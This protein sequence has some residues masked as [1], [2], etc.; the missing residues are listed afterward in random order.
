MVHH[1]LG[2][3]RERRLP[4]PPWQGTTLDVQPL[5]QRLFTQSLKS[6][7]FQEQP[8]AAVTC[9]HRL[10]QGNQKVCREGCNSLSQVPE[11]LCLEEREP[12]PP[13]S[14]TP[15]IAGPSLSTATW[16]CSASILPGKGTV[17]WPR[18]VQAH[19]GAQPSPKVSACSG[20]TSQG[21]H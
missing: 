5:Q 8:E 14:G 1:F 20:L 7:H 15:S 9:G 17:Q 3:G 13:K 12:P 4:S 10:G 11:S 2:K 6:A 19:K 18:A 16:S 21:S